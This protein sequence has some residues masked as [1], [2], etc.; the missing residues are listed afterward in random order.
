MKKVIG[1]C[2]EK[3][4]FC[5]NGGACRHQQNE[6]IVIMGEAINR[7]P[8]KDYF[9]GL[10]MM[11]AFRS[12]DPSTQVGCVLAKENKVAGT[13][14]NGYPKGVDPFTWERSLDAPFVD[15]K[16][17]YVVHAEVNAV[18]NAERADVVGSV[19]YMTLFPCNVCANIMISAGVK[20]VIYF[21][22]KYH[23][24]DFSKAARRILRAAKVPFRQY[25]G[26]I[27]KLWVEKIRGNK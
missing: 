2:D 18:I 11:A 13:G 27:K 25:D 20:E 7:L 14:Y 26:V 22:D 9:M 6:E 21:D 17:S 16:Y 23:D 4:C 15:Q 1:N 5:D 24:M 12:P 10:A 8:W 3:V 19:A